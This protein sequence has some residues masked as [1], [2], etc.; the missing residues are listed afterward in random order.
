[1]KTQETNHLDFA[2]KLTSQQILD[3]STLDIA[4]RFWESE[5]Y[6]AAKTCY[7]AMRI[8]DDLIDNRKVATHGMS[9]VEKQRLTAMVNDWLEAINYATPCDSVQKQLVETITKFQIPM[10]VWQRFSKSIIYDIRHDGFRTFQI[11]L[12]YTEGAAVAPAS[13]FVHLGSVLK[14]NGCYRAPNFDIRKAAR[15]AA[16]F[17]YLVHVVRDFQ[18]DQNNNQNYF[19]A[20]LMTENGLNCQMLKEIAAGGE[21]S[22]AFR[23]LMR[24]YYS[25]A[26]YYGRKARRM[27]DKIGA[28]LEPRYRLS[29]EIVYN[30]YR[31][32]FERIDVSNGKFTTVE[33]TPSPEEINDRIDL[34][35]SNANLL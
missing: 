10:W 5:R 25:L 22:S 23:S 33:L 29:L 27:I 18:R 2:Q 14:K 8:I 16:L 12:R 24:K 19:A 7:Q 9:E 15:P 11:F 3:N 34:T 28:Y 30:L 21:I 20:N 13:I 32:V 35:I 4:A 17:C 1:M 31:L 26:D 6:E